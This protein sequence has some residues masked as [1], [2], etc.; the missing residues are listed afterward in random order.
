MIE[1][2]SDGTTMEIDVILEDGVTTV[3]GTKNDISVAVSRRNTN[4]AVLEDNLIHETVHV[5][6]DAMREFAEGIYGVLEISEYEPRYEGG[7]GDSELSPKEMIGKFLA[8]LL[9]DEPDRSGLDEEALRDCGCSDCVKEL[10]RRRMNSEEEKSNPDPSRVGPV[11]DIG[12][13]LLG[14]TKPDA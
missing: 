13:W 7:T 6:I 8:A 11:P 10:E 5:M 14:R 1:K 9:G 3:I 4:V 12:R 2:V